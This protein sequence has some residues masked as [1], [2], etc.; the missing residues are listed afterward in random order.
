MLSTLQEDI[1]ELDATG[2]THA[3]RFKEF[4]LLSET[5]YCELYSCLDGLRRSIFGV[6]GKV[7]GVQNEST[8]RLFKRANERKYGPEFPEAIRSKLDDAWTSWFRGIRDIRTE[9]THGE[10]GSC[11]LDKESK[12]VTYFQHG[13]KQ[14][15]GVLIIKD[16]VSDVNG[17]RV[18]ITTL[19]DAIFAHWYQQLEYTERTIPCGIWRGRFYQRVVGPEAAL[20]IASG[21]CESVNWFRHDTE[22]ACPLRESCGAYA[23]REQHVRE[24][25]YRKWIERGWPLWDTD[26]DWSQAEDELSQAYFSKYSTMYSAD[27]TLQA[28]TQ[29]KGGGS[30]APS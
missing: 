7:R 29:P 22:N 12:T 26:Q 27:A 17:V 4:A 3:M 8:E 1:A 18:K 21:E 10:V 2:M 9:V 16:V 30:A 25:A 19:I 24:L 15:G 20:T 11:H 14:G 13:L 23:R 5:M 28:A 6:Y